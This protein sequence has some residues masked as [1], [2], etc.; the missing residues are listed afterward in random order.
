[1]RFKLIGY[2][3]FSLQYLRTYLSS[4]IHTWHG[5]RL[6]DALYAHARFDDLD[7]DAASQWVGR[8]GKKLALHALGN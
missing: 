5:G 4:Y 8:K 3:R 2:I 1:M 6:M 7:L